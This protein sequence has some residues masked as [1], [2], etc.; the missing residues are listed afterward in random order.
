MKPETTLA[1][2]SAKSENPF[3]EEE[4]LLS[5]AEWL[6]EHLPEESLDIVT[7]WQIRCQIS[8]E[9]GYRFGKIIPES[10]EFLKRP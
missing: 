2:L 10:Y 1:S 7:P 4:N 3:F 8:S 5:L 6:F 9:K